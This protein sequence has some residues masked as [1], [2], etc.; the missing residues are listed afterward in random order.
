M[1]A[2]D[3]AKEWLRYAKSDLNTAKHM[4]KDVNPKEIEI[5][6]YHSQ[7]CAEKSLKAYLIARETTHP[8]IHD[9]V[10]LITLCTVVAPNFS[11][12]KPYCVSLNPY[13]VQVR[14]PNELAVDDS[15]A[16]QAI[17]YSEKI[18]EF[19][20]KMINDMCHDAL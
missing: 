16:G 7:Q 12:I 1:T 9:L 20:E 19:C 10:E 18:L 13:G 5:S 4:F 11:T 17:D 3:L 6:C 2:L 15:I 8:Y 14:Y